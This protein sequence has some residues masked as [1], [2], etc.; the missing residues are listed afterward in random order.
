MMLLRKHPALWRKLFVIREL[1]SSW[2]H[3]HRL[4]TGAP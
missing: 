4:L 3:A 1:E 2:I